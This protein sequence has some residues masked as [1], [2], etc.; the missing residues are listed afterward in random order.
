MSQNSQ[1]HLCAF[2]SGDMVSIAADHADDSTSAASG[3]EH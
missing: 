2:S 1:L 3:V